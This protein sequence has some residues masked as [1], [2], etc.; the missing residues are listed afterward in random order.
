MR[1]YPMLLLL[2]LAACSTPKLAGFDKPEVVSRNEVIQANKDCINALMKPTIQYAPQ[3]T[4]HG[5]LM[6]PV[7]VNCEPYQVK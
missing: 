1:L 5:T 7:F 4:D 2:L 6:L 3:K